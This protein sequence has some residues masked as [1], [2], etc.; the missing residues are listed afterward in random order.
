MQLKVVRNYQIILA[1]KVFL[2]KVNHVVNLD[3]II[4]DNNKIEIETNENKFKRNK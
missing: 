2:H 1:L 4:F 3:H